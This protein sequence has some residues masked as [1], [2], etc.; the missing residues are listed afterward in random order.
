[1]LKTDSTN[2]NE[3]ITQQN[4]KY[5]HL[6]PLTKSLIIP[7]HARGHRTTVKS[8]FLCAVPMPATALIDGSVA[9]IYS[10]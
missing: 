9:Q 6:K 8:S 7:D 10:V 2:L 1:M 5:E 4:M 3:Y